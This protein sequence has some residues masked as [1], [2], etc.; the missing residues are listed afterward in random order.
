MTVLTKIVRSYEKSNDKLLRKETPPIPP[1]I[2]FG[3]CAWGAS[4]CK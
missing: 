3:G 1:S 4:F 2:Y